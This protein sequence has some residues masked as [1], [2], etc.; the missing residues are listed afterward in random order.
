MRRVQLFCWVS[1][2]SCGGR[3]SHAARKTRSIRVTSLVRRG[4]RPSAQLCT[5]PGRSASRK[6]SRGLGGRE[7]CG[8]AHW[9]KPTVPT[10]GECNP[11]FEM[12]SCRWAEFCLVKSLPRTA[13]THY[14]PHNILDSDLV[15]KNHPTV[16]LGL[17]Y[18]SEVNFIHKLQINN[19][20]FLSLTFFTLFISLNSF[21][22]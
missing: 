16:Q 18:L 2:A 19:M 17:I 6:F 21:I 8:S 22:K 11:G 3:N 4:S 14:S 7:E 13:Q 10:D 9:F 15:N 1:D 20:L 5:R 12:C